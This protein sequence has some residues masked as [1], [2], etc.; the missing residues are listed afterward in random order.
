MNTTTR[1]QLCTPLMIAA[2][3]TIGL[4]AANADFVGLTS[5]SVAID[6]S[7][8]VGSDARD[9]YLVSVYAEFDDAADRLV[10]VYGSNSNA[11]NL[12]VTTDDPS[13][14]WQ[15]DQ[16]GGGVP[17]S[18]NTSA[19]IL[20]ADVSLFGSAAYDSYLTIG[21]VGGA[22]DNQLQEVGIEA[23]S[24]WDSFNDGSGSLT[25]TDGALF[26]TPDDPQGVAGDYADNKVLVGQFAVGAGTNLNATFNMQWRNNANATQYSTAQNVEVAVEG[27]DDDHANHYDDFDGN[28]HGDILWQ[29]N[30]TG[31]LACWYMSTDGSGEPVFDSEVVY[32]GNISN[33]TIVG[34]GDFDGNG[35]TDILWQHDTLGSLSV[36]YMSVDGSGNPVSV[37][38]SVYSGSITGW[39]IAGFGDFDGSGTQD[40]LWQNTTTGS[41]SIWYMSVDGSGNPV[42]VSKS[43]YSGSITGWS[44]AGYGDFDGSGTQDFLWQNTTT[45]SL[46]IWYMSVDGAGNPAFTSKSAY[47]GY[48]LGWSI[49]GFGDF[50]GS[51]TQDILWQNNATGSLSIWYMS[52]DGS[53]SPV[54]SSKV[55]YAGNISTW[56]IVQ[57]SDYDANGTTDI[58]WQNNASGSLQAWMMDVDGSSNPTFESKT[59]YA[60]NIAAYSIIN[61]WPE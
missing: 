45:G 24:E 10:A 2:A 61:G 41:L 43:A 42:F 33:W 32:P 46:S 7:G 12:V 36:W 20:A 15:Y 17:G 6:Q 55:A 13:G 35:T 19:D 34:Y 4:T 39:S 5:D 28:W 26:T 53:G 40:I 54:F 22:A 37:S 23:N 3:S 21:F 25:V 59:V 48:I 49:A 44:I 11:T 8:W 60:G 50:D 18:Y 14:F 9:L 16:N 1:T 27:G 51:G 52:V 56:T 29:H 58:L 31:S 38:E 57:Y 47:S 30:T